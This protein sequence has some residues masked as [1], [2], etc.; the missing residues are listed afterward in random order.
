MFKIFA[1][2]KQK[3]LN[4]YQD[5]TLLTD[6]SDKLQTPFRALFYVV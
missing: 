6:L 4:L 5:G 1:N 2:M 3:V